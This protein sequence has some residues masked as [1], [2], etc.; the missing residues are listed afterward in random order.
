MNFMS[1][2]AGGKFF[3][4]SMTILLSKTNLAPN[5]M[6]L[7]CYCFCDSTC[8]FANVFTGIP[9]YIM[10]P[11]HQ[12][13]F[14]RRLMIIYSYQVKMSSSN[15]CS[16]SKYVK[17]YMIMMAILYLISQCYCSIQGFL[18]QLTAFFK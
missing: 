4:A 7:C 13:I 14:L 11:Y 16:S 10:L 1:P 18:W 9:T 3:Y 17:N 8:V 2:Y 12:V 5:S 6:T 15:Y